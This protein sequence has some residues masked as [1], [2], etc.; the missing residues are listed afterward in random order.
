M[1]RVIIV[2]Q[3]M[4]G[5]NG[6]WRP[7][8]KKELK[9]DG[10]D[11]LIPEMPDIDTPIIEKWIDKLTE[12]V[13]EPDQNTFFVGHSIGC[14]AILRYLETVDSPIGGAVFVAGWFDLKNLESKEVEDIA[15]PWFETPIDFDKVHSVLPK[16]T[17]IISDSD[18]FGCFEENRKKF[19]KI[20]T[21]E[22]VMHNAGHITAED[23]FT[24][25]PEAL[26]ELVTM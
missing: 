10:Y 3:W 15:R 5:A 12:V 26:N 23:G 4:A 18:P 17:L 11:V 19:T 6:D 16:A 8:L 14:Q 22:I 1:K 13:G 2:H 7:W 9:S 20:V 25:L 24:E 21:K